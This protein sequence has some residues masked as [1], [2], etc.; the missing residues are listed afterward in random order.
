[1][2]HAEK[3]IQES[4]K[5]TQQHSTDDYLSFQSSDSINSDD[6]STKTISAENRADNADNEAI[7]DTGYTAEHNIKAV[8]DNVNA[9]QNAHISF[10]LVLIYYSKYTFKK[11]KYFK[12]RPCVNFKIGK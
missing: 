7:L 12:P 5:E 3:N 4:Y 8:S 1:L 11:Q 2:D 10:N 6:T 9:I